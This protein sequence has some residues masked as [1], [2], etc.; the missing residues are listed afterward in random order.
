[1]S[2]YAGQH[3]TC[4]YAPHGIARALREGSFRIVVLNVDWGLEGNYSRSY[5]RG[6]DD[7]LAAHDHVLLVRHGHAT[8]Q[9]T[10]QVLDAI[11]PR[12]VLRF[13]AHLTGHESAGGGD[14]K[15][16]FAANVALQ[17]R[18]LVDRGHRH[19]AMAL[20]DHDSPLLEAR[21]RFARET[22]AVP[23]PRRR[24][25]NDGRPAVCAPR[26]RGPSAAPSPPGFCPPR[27]CISRTCSPCAASRP[28]PSVSS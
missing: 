10:Q 4:G 23:A 15:D 25:R 11:A 27:C 7:E 18:Y 26:P 14:W 3:A 12:A 19:I 8:P 1:M 13:A 5:I 9:S 22:T 20:P 21:L 2:A 17:I 24:D 6:L 28:R 16:G